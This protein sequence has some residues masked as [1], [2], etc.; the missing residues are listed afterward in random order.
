MPVRVRDKRRNH[1]EPLVVITL[2]SVWVGRE[3]G[4]STAAAKM[5]RIEAWKWERIRQL[6]ERAS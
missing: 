1:W 4:D 2:C 5:V 6:R 3:E